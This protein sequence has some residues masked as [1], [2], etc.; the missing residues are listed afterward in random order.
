MKPPVFES[1][2]VARL[3]W[4]TIVVEKP[5]G[6]SAS[7]AVGPTVIR[8]WMSA[9]A[10]MSSISSSTV[11]VIVC[12]WYHGVPAGSWASTGSAAQAPSPESNQRLMPPASDTPPTSVFWID[13]LPPI[14]PPPIR[15]RTGT[16]VCV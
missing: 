1:T 13:L 16:S 15:V 7:G 12:F 9:V 4:P 10:P 2:D 3:T 6:G 14:S 8:C 5:A 11:N